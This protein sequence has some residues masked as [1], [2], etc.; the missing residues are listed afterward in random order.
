MKQMPLLMVPVFLLAGAACTDGNQT[1]EPD[2]PS[3]VVAE[4][5]S[6]KGEATEAATRPEWAGMFPDWYE[7]YEPFRVIG[8]IYYVGTQGLSSFLITSGDGH[9]LLD[10][11]LDEKVPEIVSN[12][13]QLGFEPTDIKYLLNSHAH[14][15]HSGGLARMKEL[16]GAQ[17]LASEGDRSALEGGFYLGF[18]DREDLYAPKVAVDRLIE[19]GERLALGEI[20]LTARLTPGHTRGCTSWETSVTEEG[21]AFQV[22]MFCSASVAA[23]RLVG[24]PQ[25][26]GIVEDYRYTFEVTRNWQPDVFLAN[27]PAFFLMDEKREKL[28]AGD[29]LA[30]VDREAFPAFIARTE[31]AFEA[32]LERQSAET[33]AAE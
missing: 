17:F 33:N 30:F 25:Y 13:R 22:L 15:D 4:N 32:A 5:S 8:N 12:I 16:T 29:A 6:E 27:H 1:K 2:R 20:T 23:N 24:P 9:I 3:A 31:S 18:E 26:E 14:F 11:P 7:P 10:A 19:D 21:Q 28:E